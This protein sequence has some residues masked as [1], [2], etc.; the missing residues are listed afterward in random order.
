MDSNRM[1]LGVAAMKKEGAT[2]E[3]SVTTIWIA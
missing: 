2:L 1:Q 3:F